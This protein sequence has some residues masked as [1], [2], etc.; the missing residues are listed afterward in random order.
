MTAPGDRP[1]GDAS[2]RRIR[3]VHSHADRHRCGH[4]SGHRQHPVSVASAPPI[5]FV[6]G[7][8]TTGNATSE[9]VKVPSAVAAGNALVLVATGAGA[10]AL[11]GPA[12]WTLVDT[13]S[14]SAINSNVWR[15]IATGADAGTTVTV[16]FPGV[17][18][19]TVQ[20]LA[21]S[22]TNATNPIVAFAK[23]AVAE[24]GDELPEPDDN[25]PDSRRRHADL[26]GLQVVD[27]DEVE[28]ALRA[29]RPVD[30][31]RHRRRPDHLRLDRCRPATRWNDRRF[32]RLAGHLGDGVRG[33]DARP[34]VGSLESQLIP[35]C[36]LRLVVCGSAVCA[37]SGS[38]KSSS[39]VFVSE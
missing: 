38:P 10:G 22:G 35:K 7:V 15:R 3:T 16:K 28:R 29:D 36:P 14:A 20:L 18:K 12:G 13:A 30:G 32:D 11:T 17:E 27:R 26:L 4:R 25:G 24:N 39:T 9:A 6:A 19:G 5:A 21:Y 33:V 1:D 23:S 34:G 2:V 8:S 37:S 31:V